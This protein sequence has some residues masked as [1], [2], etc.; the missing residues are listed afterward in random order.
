MLFL[1]PPPTPGNPGTGTLLPSSRESGREIG[2]SCS[3]PWWTTRRLRLGGRALCPRLQ[4]SS[5][6]CQL[7]RGRHLPPLLWRR[8]RK[9]RSG[10]KNQRKTLCA[11]TRR[12]RAEPEEV[13][14]GEA[15]IEVPPEVG[16]RAFPMGRK[17]EKGGPAAVRRR[18]RR[19]MK[20]RRIKA[21]PR[22][23][24]G[25]RSRGMIAIASGAKQT[26]VGGSRCEKVD[27]GRRR[28]RRNLHSG[29]TRPMSL[30]RIRKKR[31]RKKRNRTPRSRNGQ[32]MSRNRFTTKWANK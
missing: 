11:R 2:T 4:M 16:G 12:W 28:R 14:A 30:T 27:P 18:R 25:Q 31:K 15:T 6:S 19:R 29:R 24:R 21:A 5:D 23:C 13:E 7:H 26:V 3:L 17:M 8:S 20:T 22:R 1:H 10:G 9:M 32:L